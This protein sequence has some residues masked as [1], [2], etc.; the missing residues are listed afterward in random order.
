MAA[1]TDQ[2]LR[3]LYIMN[4]LLERTDEE[5][6]LNA[7]EIMQILKTEHDIESDRKT[8]YGAV[9]TLKKY[10]LDIIQLKGKIS[11]Y[12]IGSRSFELPE[13]KLLVDAVQSSKFITS[14]KSEELI[15][16]LEKLTSKYEADQLQRQVFIYN[17]IKTENETIYYN[18]DLIYDSIYH[19]RQITFQ[20]TE[21]NA[22]KELVLKH[23]GELYQV[24]PWALS[25]DDENYYLIAYDE[26]A[27]IIK[28]YRVDKIRHLTIV[29]E[30]RVGEEHFN[31][32]DL[33]VFAKKTFGMYGGEDESVTL[34]CHNSLAGVVI[35]RFGQDVWMVPH[36][37]EHFRVRV[38]V[39]VS[40]QFFGW[41]TGIGDQM[42]IL[43]PER[44]KED[45]RLYLKKILEQY[46]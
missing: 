26:K 11:G 17:R 30:E 22:R 18:V 1:G 19:N 43:E 35:D 21:W 27:N 5:H 4:I 37:K 15:K 34:L 29:D 23:A 45:Y 31:N 42:Q 14:K 32:F 13:L 33:A 39:T 25:W 16:K 40:R 28:H 2:K 41:I 12:Y 36:D 7:T 3:I 6:F 24:S 46:N 20:Y 8:I 9:E 10:G 44:I 38:D